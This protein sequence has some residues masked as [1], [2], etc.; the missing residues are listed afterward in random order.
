MQL[1]LCA[2]STAEAWI[3]TYSYTANLGKT[4]DLT[5]QRVLSLSVYKK[6]NKVY[7]HFSMFGY[8][9]DER[10][11]GPITCVIRGDSEKVKVVYLDGLESDPALPPLLE[12]GSVLF[13]LE[14]AKQGDK[15]MLMTQFKNEDLSEGARN[16]HGKCFS[17]IH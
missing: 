4:G 13:T 2:Q 5:M 7:A 16:L 14:W 17:K 6:K 15:T 3:G 1:P 10:W 12:R 8:Q 9:V 11:D